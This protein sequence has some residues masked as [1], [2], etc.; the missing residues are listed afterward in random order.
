MK[1]EAKENIN[2]ILIYYV[3]LGHTNLYRK[4]ITQNLTES[5]IIELAFLNPVIKH[6][7]E[8]FGLLMD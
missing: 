8:N 4:F 5:V 7:C 2:N 1:Y 3:H 6:L